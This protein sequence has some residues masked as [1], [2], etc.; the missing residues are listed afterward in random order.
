MY[1]M[2]EKNAPEKVRFYDWGKLGELF[3]MNKQ[4]GVF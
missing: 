1:E 3:K 4:N 2:K